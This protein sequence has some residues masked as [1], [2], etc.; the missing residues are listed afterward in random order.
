[1]NHILSLLRKWSFVKYS[2]PL[3]PKL[4]LSIFIHIFL[5]I[6]IL[7]SPLNSCYSKKTPKDISPFFIDPTVSKPEP[8]PK[9]TPSQKTVITQTTPKTQDTKE[10]NEFALAKKKAVTVNTNLVKKSI[11]DDKNKQQKNTNKT[12]IQTEKIREIQKL[13]KSGISPVISQTTYHTSSQYSSYPDSYVSGTGRG[14]SGANDPVSLYYSAVYATL[15]E[16]WQQPSEMA[17]KGLSVTAIIRVTKEG[18]I[19][20]KKIVRKSYNN[21]MDSSVEAALDN[22]L[23]LPPFPP[24]LGP[25]PR[26]IT[27]EFVLTDEQK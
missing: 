1:M 15:Y 10:E 11:T 8:M 25:L 26:T 20:D 17:G 23:R 7:W 12:N 6:L 19:L 22:V 13:L 4:I 18:I 27:I 16:A 3:T 2:T 5:F 9:S 24:E 14:V 21:I